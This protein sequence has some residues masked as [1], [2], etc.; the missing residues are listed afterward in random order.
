M[1]PTIR[2]EESSIDI[3]TIESDSLGIPSA[4]LSVVLAVISGL[5]GA[6][7]LMGG[8]I[9]YGTASKAVIARLVADGRIVSLTMTDQQLI[10]SIHLL[11]QGTGIGL[12][13]LAFVLFGLGGLLIRRIQN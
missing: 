7:S 3:E 2:S 1:E 6:L 12:V 4:R 11:Q 10:N 13:V 8:I 5:A 9:L